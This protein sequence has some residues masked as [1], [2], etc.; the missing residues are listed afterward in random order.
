MRSSHALTAVLLAAVASSATAQ[1][2]SDAS[3]LLVSNIFAKQATD[4]AQKTRAQNVLFYYFGRL[5]GRYNSA[6]LKDALKAAGNNLLT[7][8]SAVAL[9][10]SCA[11]NMEAR[12]QA[13]QSI[14]LQLQKAAPG[15]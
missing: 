12:G 8:Q 9:M 10:N 1:N 7:A 13:L 15:K 5:D 14:A 3:C 11:R 2:P 4:S 6:Q